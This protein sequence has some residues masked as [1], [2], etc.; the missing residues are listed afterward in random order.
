MQL[1]LTIAIFCDFLI[2]AQTQRKNLLRLLSRARFNTDTN[3]FIQLKGLFK[4][5][6]GFKSRINQYISDCRTVTSTCKFPI[7]VYHCAMKNQCLKE[8]YFELNIMMKVKDSRQL[9][10][11]ENHFLKKGY[12]TI[13]F[14]EYLNA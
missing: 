2:L 3:N 7:N 5:L 12:D 14:P 13:N 4:C 8:P 1:K 9:E 10:F 11:Y 6:N